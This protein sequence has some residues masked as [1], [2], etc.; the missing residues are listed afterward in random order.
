MWV[1]LCSTNSKH[2][3]D[4]DHLSIYLSI[5]LFIYSFITKDKVIFGVIWSQLPKTLYV[6]FYLFSIFQHSLKILDTE[7]VMMNEPIETGNTI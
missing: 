3:N 4:S 1:L 5:Y 6:L 2:S 7:K